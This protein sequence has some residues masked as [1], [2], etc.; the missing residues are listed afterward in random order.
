MYALT[1]VEKSNGTNDLG[2]LWAPGGTLR[3]IEDKGGNFVKKLEK[4]VQE[5]KSRLH[6]SKPPLDGSETEDEESGSQADRSR[7]L[8]IAF[9]ESANSLDDA[10]RG[11]RGSTSSCDSTTL[12]TSDWASNTQSENG[13][14]PEDDTIDRAIREVEESLPREVA[15]VNFVH[16]RRL[17]ALL[18]PKLNSTLTMVPLHHRHNQLDARGGTECWT[19]ASIDLAAGVVRHYNPAGLKHVDLEHV[20]RTLEPLASPDIY[21]FE[22]ATVSRRVYTDGS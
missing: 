3:T 1:E 2:T 7:S 22:E 12:S 5:R 4:V 13:S 21:R 8:S 6:G 18:R 10:G 20:R 16:P 19:V 15:C 17:R 14:G 11:Q 9:D